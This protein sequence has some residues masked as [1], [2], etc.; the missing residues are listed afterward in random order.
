[1]KQISEEINFL[2]ISLMI[3]IY[4]PPTYAAQ[5]RTTAD[6]STTPRGSLKSRMF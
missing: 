2:I 5:L 6:A 1:M 3:G 4:L